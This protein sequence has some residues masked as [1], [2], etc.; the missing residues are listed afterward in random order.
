M[1]RLH[2]I[3]LL[4]TTRANLETQ[5]A[6]AGLIT[7]E[8]Y[9]VTDEQR[10]AIATDSNAYA[11]AAMSGGLNE[12]GVPTSD[13]LATGNMTTAFN[14]G[15]TSSAV[16][17]LVYLDSNATWQKAHKGTSVATY[18]GLLAVALEVKT[19]GQALKVALS[20]SMVYC[21]AFPALTVGAPVYMGD[22]GSIVV[23][24]PSTAD[25]AIRVIGWGIHADKLY[26][27]PS[28]DYIIHT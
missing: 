1:A 10:M 11:L 8:P 28:P 6:A 4:R 5:R 23:I 15:Y 7:G 24:Q 18:S 2:T 13:G 25:H 27:C 14:C 9:L 20:G 21:T 22:A 16:G 17:D 19:T 12:L 3:K 26:F